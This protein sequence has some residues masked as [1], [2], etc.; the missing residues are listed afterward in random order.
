MLDVVA[1]AVLSK[2]S[3]RTD[4]PPAL[5]L[6]HNKVCSF[7]RRDHEIADP[8]NGIGGMRGGKQH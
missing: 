1:R 3:V 2:D 6:K 7:F 8:E 5:G 4:G